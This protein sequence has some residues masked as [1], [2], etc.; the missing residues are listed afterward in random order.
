[1]SGAYRFLLHFFLFVLILGLFIA[2]LCFV[3]SPYS[4]KK[5]DIAKDPIMTHAITGE[6]VSLD[7]QNVP[8]RLKPSLQEAQMDLLLHFSCCM[9][10]A[11]IPFWAVK[12]TLLATIRHARLI[13]WDDRICVAILHQDLSKLVRIRA[14]LEQN[15]CMAKLRVTKH[16]Y[17]FA[18]TNMT[19]FPCIEIDIMK[20]KDHEVSI[21]TPTD[22]LGECSFQ[23]SFLRRREVFAT[24]MVFPLRMSKIDTIDIAVPQNAE[25]CL[26]I[27][28][29]K[30]W[31][32]ISL[33]SLWK[34]VS[35]SA[36]NHYAQ[37]IFPS[38][39]MF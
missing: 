34:L 12:S 4:F 16:G 10:D 27:L 31:K 19:H 3:T 20:T 39:E 14:R 2:T 22:E 36:S 13:P 25:Q 8:F 37:R 29:N 11:Q 23:D 26:D 38:L 32:T 33:W 9:K 6:R 17:V 5:I 1:M 24:N 15:A 7:F 18:A 28:Y 21:C 30:Q 35:H